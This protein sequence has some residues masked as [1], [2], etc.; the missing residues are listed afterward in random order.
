MAK[1]IVEYYPML[2]DKDLPSKYMGIYS[3]LH[4]RILN[5]KSPQK[6]QG[7]TPERGRLKKRRRIEFSPPDQEEDNDAE[8]C[9]GS[10]VLA[11]PRSSSDSDNSSD[12]DSRVTQARHYK[13]LQAMYKKPKPNQDAVRQ[14]LDLE[15][16]SRR[17]FID[18]DV[19][20]E[21]ER[22]GK[23]L[24]AYPCFKELYNVMDELRRILDKGN[25]TFLTEL[26]KRWDDFCSTVQFYGV[27]KKVLKPPMNLDKVKH[28]IALF[29]VLPML[30]PSPAVPPKKLGHAS[31]ALIHVLQPTEDPAM[32]LQKSSI[33]GPVLLLGHP[34]LWH[35]KP[36]PSPHLQKKTSVKVCCI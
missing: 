20:K 27:W 28:N 14:I 32:Y 29:R 25:C 4:K 9:G 21:E 19:L 34:V 7:P 35:W 22:A 30:F 12:K 31:E 33:L 11:L 5:A 17:A 3:Y 2:Q 13:T 1:K 36:L 18:S 8:S 26:K 15:F 6:R 16:Q 24:K 10:T 23:I